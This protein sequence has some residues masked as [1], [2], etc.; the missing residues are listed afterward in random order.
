M[1]LIMTSSSSVSADQPK[2]RVPTIRV[3]CAMSCEGRVPFRNFQIV[4]PGS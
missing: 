2:K 1:S 3:L 4:T